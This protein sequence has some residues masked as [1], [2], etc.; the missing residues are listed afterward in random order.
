MQ[1]LASDSVKFAWLRHQPL[2]TPMPPLG[3]LP[4]EQAQMLLAPDKLDRD[5]L[6][7]DLVFDLYRPAQGEREAIRKDL[8]ER[9]R[10]GRT[11]QE[12]IAAVSD[13]GL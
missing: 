2:Q 8:V 13:V 3:R 6:F 11:E 10:C 9:S 4:E 1:R 7:F 5:L 12:Q